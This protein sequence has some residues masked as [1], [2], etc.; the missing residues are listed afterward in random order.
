MSTFDVIIVG[1]GP[2]GSTCAARL[3]HSGLTVKLL[4]KKDFPR[5]KPCAGWITPQVVDT[6]Q[7]DIDD[8]CRNNTFQP[9]TGFR[10]GI[11]GG[12]VV[13]TDYDHPV[14][15]GIRRLE[16]D[17]YLLKRSGVLCEH[18]NVKQLRRHA[19]Q[20]SVNE[21][22]RAPLLIGAGGHFCPVARMARG[23]S[24]HRSEKSD[25]TVF[26]QEIEFELADSEASS[27]CVDPEKPEL[28]FCPDLRGYGWC[29]RKDNYLNVGLG[30][31]EKRGLSAHVEE[32]CEFLRS[33]GKL[34]GQFPTH[35]LGHAYRLY[36][37]PE[38]KLFGEGLVLIGDSAGLAYPQS[39]E[40]IRPAIESAMIAADVIASVNG[41]YESSSLAIY[42]QRLVNRLGPAKPIQTAGWMPAALLQAIA[43]KLMATSWFSRHTVIENWFLHQ[44]QTAL[45]I[46]EPL[47]QN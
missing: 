30:R 43:A 24:S 29:L 17:D 26:A 9:I 12:R 18:Q 41:R 15:Y 6:L 5:V 8:Y 11:I 39:G 28:Y 13:E 14:S 33:R 37:K 31:T 47:V 2:A 7:I 1:A 36:A 23:E 10:T 34:A 3:K 27:M 32:F 20:W 19:D 44:R 16:F 38:P 40:G 25:Q 42:Q 4:D 21:A 45:K 46:N 35:F 22:Y